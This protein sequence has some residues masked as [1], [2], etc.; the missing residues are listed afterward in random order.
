[1]QPSFMYWNEAK[2]I[3]DS[4]FKKFMLKFND[5]DKLNGATFKKD[6]DYFIISLS[7]NVKLEKN[8][9][10]LNDFKKIEEVSKKANEILKNGNDHFHEDIILEADLDGVDDLL[11]NKK[12]RKLSIKSL[13]FFDE[14]SKKKKKCLFIH[15]I[16]N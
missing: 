15:S 5:S 6:K 9:K 13:D 1:M 16:R 10:N 12:K 7:A 11:P 4:N 14:K 3:G 8:I 2:F